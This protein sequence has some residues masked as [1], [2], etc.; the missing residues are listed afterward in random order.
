[1]AMQPATCSLQPCSYTWFLRFLNKKI[2][3]F[4]THGNDRKRRC[5]LMNRVVLGRSCTHSLAC[6]RWLLWPC[7]GRI[8][9]FW[10]GPRSLPSRK[11]L[12]LVVYQAWEAHRFNFWICILGLPTSLL[13]VVKCT[14][15]HWI[16]CISL[17]LEYS[18]YFRYSDVF[19]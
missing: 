10:Q 8:D 1:M 2:K 5:Q 7:A 6:Y 17:I 15:A 3:C 9:S 14:T 13:I 4:M 11:Y 18:E 16:P 12:L 19:K